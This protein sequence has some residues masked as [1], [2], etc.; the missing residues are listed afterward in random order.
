M[1]SLVAAVI[2]DFD[3]VLA[4]SEPLHLAG[5]RAALAMRGLDLPAEDYYALFLG[6]NDED[7]VA[8]M[9]DRYGWPLKTAEVTEVVGAKMREMSRLLAGP[10]VLY[11]GAAACVRRLSQ[12]CPLA[13]ASGAKRP[14]IQLV[15][16][17]NGLSDQFE[18]IVASGDTPR[19]KPAP[20]PYARAL[21]QLQ[22][23]GAVPIDNGIARRCVAVE[24]SRWGI[25]SARAAGLRCVALTSSYP[26]SDLREADLVIEDLDEL[27][28]DRLRVLVEDCA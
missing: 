14:E 24:D 7:A 4:N 26:A 9:A 17:A 27:T 21:E 23:L 22:T 6:Y 18:T 1:Q 8:A 20:D 25:V 2:F 16:D 13:I 12:A 28:M 10:D 3:G 11:R 5:F 15:L 19:R